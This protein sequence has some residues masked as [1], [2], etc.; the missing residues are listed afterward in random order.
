MKVSALLSTLLLLAPLA[1]GEEIIIAAASDLQFA[2]DAV[3]SEF[4]AVEADALVKVVYGSSGNFNAQITQGAP[5]DLYFSAD[6]SYPEALHAKGLAASKPKP[7]ATGR[8]VV[9]SMSED[10]SRLEWHSLADERFKR[11]AIANP[12]HAPYGER[13]EELLRTVGVLEQVRSRLVFGDNI[14]QTAQFVQTGAADVGIVALSLVL[15][16]A[17]KDSGWYQL[18][19]EELHAP[20]VQGYIVTRHAQDKPLA[21][22]FA[23]FM[24][25]PAAQ[26][27][28]AAYGFALPDSEADA[29][30]AN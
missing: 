3:I 25:S 16:P 13:A 23:S 7:Y 28:L 2:M 11:I 21:W 9:W 6:I 18:V 12:R 19:P 24:A 29:V 8:L 22:R 20:L 15:A 30:S 17:L 4:S 5:F 1:R 14:S 10:V 27:I 26:A